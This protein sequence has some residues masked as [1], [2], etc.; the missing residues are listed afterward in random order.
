MK[1][2]P[3]IFPLAT[4]S[5]EQ[6]SEI[7]QLLSVCALP[8]ADIAPSKTLLFFGCRSGN[9]LAGIIGLE[10]FGSVALLRSL[11]VAP[12]QR[13][14]GLGRSLVAYA[15]EHAASHG[16]DALYLLTTTAEAFFSRLGYTPASREA[17]PSSI[18]SAA[19]FSDLCP[20]SAAFMGK[21]LRA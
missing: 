19:Q 8:T 4:A 13:N 2:T 10:V 3:V 16:I 14:Q 21:R 20:A 1:S 9:K 7:R 11:A 17:A 18:K 6:L 12:S 15:E 5:I